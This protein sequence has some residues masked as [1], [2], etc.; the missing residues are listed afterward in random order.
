M[1]KVNKSRRHCS[2][3]HTY[4]IHK[5]LDQIFILIPGIPS[6]GQLSLIAD[7]GSRD[8]DF[9]F[10]VE[11]VLCGLCIGEDMLAIDRRV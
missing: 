1:R 7:F 4:I 11:F 5:A 10:V 3:Q 6:H 9:E 8:F 2:S